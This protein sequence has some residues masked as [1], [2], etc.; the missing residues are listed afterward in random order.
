MPTPAPGTELTVT[1]SNQKVY[2]HKIGD[3][4]S[5]DKLIYED[6]EHPDFYN[7]VSTTE[8]ERFAF[9]SSEDPSKRGNRLSV[10]DETSPNKTFR[11]LVAEITDDQ[12]LPITNIGST[13]I[14]ST[15]H[16]AP[17]SKLIKVEIDGNVPTFTDIVAEKPE[18]IE[19]VG[20]AGNHLFLTYLKDATSRV[21]VYDMSGKF[22]NKIDLPGLGTAEGFDG[23]KGDQTVY[24]T[25]ASI[26]YPD[27]V[28]R[29][30]M[31]ARTSAVFAAPKIPGFNPNDFV[32]KQVFYKSK[33]GTRVPM[34]IGYKKGLKLT[35]QNPTILYGY[36]GFDVS[37]T[38]WFSSAD[39]AWMEQGGVY[40]VA[41]LRGGGEY[42]EKWH[43]A[44]MRFNKQN[45]FDD[46]IAAA[47][48]LIAEKYTSPKRLA[49]EGGSNGGLLVGAVINQRPDLF[50]VGLPEV[51]VM[52]MLRYQKFSAGTGWVSDYGS[53]DD[54]AQFRNLIKYSPLQNIKSG[55]NYPALLVR[56][57]D[58]DDRVV[59]AHSYKYIATVQAKDTGPRPHLI[60]I[61][62]NSGHGA[63]N[64][65]KDLAQRADVMAF[66]WNNMGYTPKYPIALP[67]APA[68]K[69]K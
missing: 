60:L 51:G 45:V 34:F 43:E 2:F 58:H 5:A 28:F 49:L 46:C 57:S 19:H 18:S 50:Q 17:N 31:A 65:S 32:V 6:P 7:S 33:D 12:Y 55:V 16:D 24:Y 10:L 52:D 36:G 23:E 42:G 1:A 62:T 11:P 67:A 29:Y 35:G 64:L 22:E 69:K 47:Q 26:N 39:I 59:P 3:P 41:N 37:L 15:N 54:E 30:D 8:D 66:A 14:L 44:G 53:S 38:P 48:Y 61:E 56:T 20:S 63:S 9:L 40:A 25:Y 68:T 4:Q 21:E 27:T 13:V